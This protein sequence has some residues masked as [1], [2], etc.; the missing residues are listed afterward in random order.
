M[1]NDAMFLKCSRSSCRISSHLLGDSDMA[2]TGLTAQDALGLTL[3]V[4]HGRQEAAA[5]SYICAFGAT[6]PRH[7]IHPRTG[8]T[9]GIDITIGRATFTVCGANPRREADT[10]LPGPCAVTTPGRGSTIFQLCVEDLD[11]TVARALAHGAT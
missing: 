10:S 2:I 1:I 5:A 9:A 3:F 6:S 4:P 11:A 7:W 8:A